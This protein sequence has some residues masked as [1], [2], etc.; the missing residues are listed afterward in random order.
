MT[1]GPIPERSSERAS[2][3][4]DTSFILLP[5]TAEY[6]LLALG[7]FNGA[8]FV[9]SLFD[10]Y[11]IGMPPKLRNRPR[12]RQAAFLAGRLCAR[13]VLEHH[14]FPRFDLDVKPSGEPAWPVGMVGSLS[15]NASYAGAVAHPSRNLA[16]LGIDIETVVDDRQV[17]LIASAITTPGER[18]RL[19]ACG[20]SSEQAWL[21]T[22]VFSAKESFYKAAFP[23]VESWFDFDAIEFVRLDRQRR[24]LT[25]ACTSAL[26]TSF[27][28]GELIHAY[29]RM[30]DTSTILTSVVL[31]A[32]R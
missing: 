20:D 3:F 27:A 13:M 7:R 5:G 4:I 8:A 29:Y 32:G 9:P 18:A 12:Q 19:A 6:V 14:L 15:H 21:V 23:K 17:A 22:L 11:R 16:G 1:A 30:V 25:F 26:Q 28:K 31:M 10:A 24:L 2:R